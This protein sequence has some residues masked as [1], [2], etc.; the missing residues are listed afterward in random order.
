MFKINQDTEMKIFKGED[1]PVL[2]DTRMVSNDKQAMYFIQ[3]KG[4]GVYGEITIDGKTYIV[5]AD[6]VE[7]AF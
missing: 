7:S 5:G 3:E 1:K 2:V 4:D 6:C